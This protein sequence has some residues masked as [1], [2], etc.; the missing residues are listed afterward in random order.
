MNMYKSKLIGLISLLV[1]FSIFAGCG[2]SDKEESKSELKQTN[3]KESLDTSKFYSYNNMK[4]WQNY[5]GKTPDGSSDMAEVKGAAEIEKIKMSIM[6]HTN[7]DG[8][9]CEMHPQ[10]HQNYSG[11]CPVCKMELIKQE[12]SSKSDSPTYKS[13]K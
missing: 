8:Y 2:K 7:E 9:T 1:I 11:K 4:Y 6:G 10:V 12:K 3:K 13:I 5:P